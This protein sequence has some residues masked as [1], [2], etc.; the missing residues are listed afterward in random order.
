MICLGYVTPM[1]VRGRIAWVKPNSQPSTISK[2][3]YVPDHLKHVSPCITHAFAMEEIWK[4]PC[5]VSIPMQESWIPLSTD[6]GHWSWLT[7]D[8]GN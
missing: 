6:D 1:G 2:I 7:L 5:T 3:V 4:S 8:P